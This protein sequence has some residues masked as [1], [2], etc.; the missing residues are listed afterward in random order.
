[1]LRCVFPL[2]ALQSHQHCCSLQNTNQK[3]YF[4]SKRIGFPVGTNVH[5]DL[6]T[7]MDQWARK[8]V[9]GNSQGLEWGQAGP[10]QVV[11]GMSPCWGWSATEFGLP[12]CPCC[13]AE[14]VRS[15]SILCRMKPWAPWAVCPWL[16]SYYSVALRGLSSVSASED[17]PLSLNI[18]LKPLAILPLLWFSF[19]YFPANECG[20]WLRSV[21]Q[22]FSTDIKPKKLTISKF[23]FLTILF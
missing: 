15:V 11:P 19:M 3:I 20:K 21:H 9:S 10:F 2:S 12:C 16:L 23:Q 8:G 4:F 6:G 22:L 1:M 7:G 14:S 5:W 13:A 18:P 17:I